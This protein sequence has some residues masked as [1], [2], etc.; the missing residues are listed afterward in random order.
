MEKLLEGI[1]KCMD[2]KGITAPG[3][4]INIVER[5]IIG[6]SDWAYVTVNIFLPRKR[7]PTLCWKLAIN[8]VRNIIDWD[9]SSF[10]YL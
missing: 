4:R 9:K 6:N 2:E 1:H 8:F 3:Y 10:F 7:K 5:Q